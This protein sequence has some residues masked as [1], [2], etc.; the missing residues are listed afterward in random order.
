[1]RDLCESFFRQGEIA[2][3]VKSRETEPLRQGL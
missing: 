2:R 3:E 1:M